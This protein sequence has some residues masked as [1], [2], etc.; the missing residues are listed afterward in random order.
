MVVALKDLDVQVYSSHS[1]TQKLLLRHLLKAE[2]G[3]DWEPNSQMCR[4]SSCSEI[5]YSLVGATR[6]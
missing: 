6:Q 3:Q 4:C 1:F 5:A 2:L